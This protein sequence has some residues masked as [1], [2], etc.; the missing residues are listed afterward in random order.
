MI[1]HVMSDVAQYLVERCAQNKLAATGGIKFVLVCGTVTPCDFV[2]RRIKIV[3]HT[4]FLPRNQVSAW[5]RRG[6]KTL[7]PG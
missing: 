5:L 4:N 1:I 6:P 7:S 2:E 3:R